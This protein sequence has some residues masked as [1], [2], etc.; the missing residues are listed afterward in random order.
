MNLPLAHDR[1]YTW[2]LAARSQCQNTVAT[3][4]ERVHEKTNYNHRYV[5]AV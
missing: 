2:Y 3:M 5:T 1:D 4:A